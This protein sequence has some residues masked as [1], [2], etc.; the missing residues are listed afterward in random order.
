MNLFLTSIFPLEV[1]LAE[2]YI[3]NPKLQRFNKLCVVILERSFLSEGYFV[4]HRTFGNVWTNRGRGILLASSGWRPRI[5]L[6]IFQCVGQPDHKEFSGVQSLSHVRLCDPTDCSTPGLPIHHQLS[7]FTQT[8]VHWVSDAIQPSHPL[9][10][11]SPH[12]FNILQHQGLFK[13]VS[14]SH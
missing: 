10:S 1:C 2:T 4:L 11:P 8:H 5:L 13:W 6:N 14:S 3:L 12:T 7:E 9:A